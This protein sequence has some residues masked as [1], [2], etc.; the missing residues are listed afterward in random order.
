MVVRF[1]QTKCRWWLWNSWQ[2]W[3]RM[4]WLHKQ[5]LSP[6]N[7]RRHWLWFLP[8]TT[9]HRQKWLSMQQAELLERRPLVTNWF[10]DD[11]TP[12]PGNVQKPSTGTEETSCRSF[13]WVSERQQGQKRRLSQTLHSASVTPSHQSENSHNHL[14]FLCSSLFPASWPPP[15]RHP[16]WGRSQ[17]HQRCFRAARIQRH[18]GW[19]EKKKNGGF[20][21]SF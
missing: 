20:S 21:F 9:L 10:L 2:G 11:P 12:L 19:R 14:H 5:W 4:T 7:T 3:K 6:R 13:L 8:E 15:T 17:H 16:H 1:W 18:W